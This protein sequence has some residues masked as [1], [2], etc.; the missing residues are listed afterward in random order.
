MQASVSTV[1][2][3]VHRMTSKVFAHHGLINANE[4]KSVKINV[5]GKFLLLH[6]NRSL[7]WSGDDKRSRFVCPLNF[8]H[9]LEKNAK[10]LH[11]NSVFS[12]SQACNLVQVSV[13]YTHDSNALKKLVWHERTLREYPSLFKNP[14]SGKVG[15]FVFWF[16]NPVT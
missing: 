7:E 11:N 12:I 14:P 4:S 15:I 5:R 16:L 13:A 8:V 1:M 6:R 2:I 9:L 10:I 3:C